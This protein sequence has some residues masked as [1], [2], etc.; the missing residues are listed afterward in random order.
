MTPHVIDGRP[1]CSAV[2]Q[3]IALEQ[4]DRDAARS[5]YRERALDNHLHCSTQIEFLTSKKLLHTDESRQ[6]L[7]VQATVLHRKGVG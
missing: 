2:N 1:A 3:L 4:S 5:G 6:E 7:S